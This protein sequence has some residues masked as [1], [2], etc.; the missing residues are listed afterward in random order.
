MSNYPKFNQLRYKHYCNG[1]TLRMARN[2]DKI[3]FANVIDPVQKEFPKIINPL[4][5]LTLSF[6]CY[7][8]NLTIN[9][10][11]PITPSS[12]GRSAMISKTD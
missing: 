3:G 4:P 9:T 11:M 12:D 7:F 6:K 8:F 5:N 10:S 2:Q 1:D